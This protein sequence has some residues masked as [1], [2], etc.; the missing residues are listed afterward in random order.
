M[1]M[2]CFGCCLQAVENVWKKYAILISWSYF[3]LYG[4]DKHL[5]NNSAYMN[6]H[7]GQINCDKFFSQ[8]GDVVRVY[9][10]EN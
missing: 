2:F 6:T 1:G 4:G 9:R 10:K 5:L 8:E 7:R 3:Q